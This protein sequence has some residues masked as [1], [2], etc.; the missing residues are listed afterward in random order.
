M[1]ELSNGNTLLSNLLLEKKNKSY[2]KTIKLIV[3]GD[4]NTGK[5]TLV[6]KYSKNID[7]I[8]EMEIYNP[9]IGID[10]TTKIIEHKKVKYKIQIWDTAGQENYSSIVK[11][12]FKGSDICLLTF[13][14]DD[15]ENID[16]KINNVIHNCSNCKIFLV[17]TK[18]DKLSDESLSFN[19]KHFNYKI[20][21]YRNNIEYIGLVSSYNNLFMNIHNQK[22]DINYLFDFMVQNYTDSIDN[23]H[24]IRFNSIN[25]NHND[26]NNNNDNDNHKCC[27]I[28]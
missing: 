10:F 11:S 8:D 14:Y 6:N 1:N 3:Y 26:N 25:I 20:K 18:Y 23:I 21:N 24:S 22:Y 9:T 12:Y 15:F 5:S 27:I 7:N 16:S 17:G 28:S 4:S 19:I 2:D 13:N